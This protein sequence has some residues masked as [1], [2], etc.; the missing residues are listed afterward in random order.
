MKTEDYFFATDDWERK[1]SIKRVMKKLLITIAFLTL[2]YALI[3]PGLWTFTEMI[4]PTLGDTLF[5]RVLDLIT[6]RK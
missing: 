4:E 3:W 5:F 2:T 1:E 6:I